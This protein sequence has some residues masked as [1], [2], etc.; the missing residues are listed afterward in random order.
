MMTSMEKYLG[1]K[2][3]LKN[4]SKAIEVELFRQN[5]ILCFV[6]PLLQNTGVQQTLDTVIDYLP[7]PLDV[8]PLPEKDETRN[9]RRTEKPLLMNHLLPSCVATDPFIE[10]WF[11]VLGVMKS[12]SPFIVHVLETK[13]ALDEL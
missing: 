8:P 9:K 3:F 2:R 5:S 6:D 1:E 13:S 12:G 4:K 10:T 7:S 11:R